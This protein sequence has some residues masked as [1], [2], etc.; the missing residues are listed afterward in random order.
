MFRKLHIAYHCYYAISISHLRHTNKYTP[1]SE[2]NK[3]SR[4]ALAHNFA[5]CV[6]LNE[7]KYFDF[8]CKN[9]CRKHSNTENYATKA[10]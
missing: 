3:T 7:Q 1:N 8:K 10:E 4:Q 2:L 6:N 5:K 9:D